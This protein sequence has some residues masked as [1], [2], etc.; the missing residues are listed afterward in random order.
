LAL[1][2][3]LIAVG[4]IVLSASGTLAGRLGKDTAFAVT[5]VAGIIVL[6]SGFIVAS[7]AV[8]PKRSVNATLAALL[9][10]SR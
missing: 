7:N 8:T 3:V 6:F 5:L 1:G 2:N 9:S 4:A 10:P